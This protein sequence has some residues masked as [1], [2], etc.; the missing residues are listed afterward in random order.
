MNKNIFTDE[1]S[2][3]PKRIKNGKWME[4]EVISVLN[5]ANSSDLIIK[6]KQGQRSHLDLDQKNQILK[7]MSSNKKVTVA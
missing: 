1:Q 7:L 2:F 3:M 4:I 5:F 6:P